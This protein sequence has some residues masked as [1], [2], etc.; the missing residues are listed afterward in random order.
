[1]SLEVYIGKNKSGKTKK[2]E[3]RKKL[4]EINKKRVLYIPSVINLKSYIEKEKSGANKADPLTPQTIVI[5]FI[6]EIYSAVKEINYDEKEKE[7]INENIKKLTILKKSILEN[8][9]NDT[10]FDN[11][12]AD[13]LL[14][15]KTIRTNVKTEKIKLLSFK[16]EKDW[17]NESSSGST[18]YSILKLLS[19]FIEWIKDNEP[20]LDLNLFSLIIDEV[21]KFSHPELIQKTA[22]EILKI[23]K[24][25]DV[26][27]S[28]HSPQ[29]IER[30][31][32]KRDDKL[33]ITFKWLFA[34]RPTIL[35]T[36]DEA[37]IT[38]QDIIYDEIELFESD[39]LI[40]LN[41]REVNAIVKCLFS[42]N[43]I[44]VEGLA[45]QDFLESLREKYFNENYVTIID[46]NS[47][48]GVEKIYKKMKK[49]KVINHINTLLFYDEDVERGDDNSWTVRK[50]RITIEGAS[51]IVQVPNLED[52]FFLSRK[53]E[54]S[55]KINKPSREY[56][57]KNEKDELKWVN[58][59]S[60]KLTYSDIENSSTML[61][62]VEK[63]KKIGLK[64]QNWVK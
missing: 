31:L 54:N 34:N 40:D 37:E 50:K 36:K 32:N 47:R 10:F 28:T 29:L 14:I 4:D 12:I 41:Y 6:N 25:I 46:C 27:I 21:E 45:D 57:I 16:V 11:S 55:D 23:S 18:N 26:V 19:G 24:Y 33:Q 53:Y 17:D 15:D 61:N 39:A 49:M 63:M 35:V 20:K 22:D 59:K 5:D 30:I 52:E 51:S 42:S 48:S 3:E 58:K 8:S 38:P 43:V 9:K 44:L 2:I 13:A 56:R 62:V 64:I 7:I 60:L 1:M